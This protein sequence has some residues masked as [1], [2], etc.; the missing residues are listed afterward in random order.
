MSLFEIIS[1]AY[2]TAA[3][4]ALLSM[5][6]EEEKKD[7]ENQLTKMILEDIDN[8]RFPTKSFKENYGRAESFIK[9]LFGDNCNMMEKI[10]NK[11]DENKSSVKFGALKKGDKFML[12]GSNSRTFMKISLVI[13]PRTGNRINAICIDDKEDRY[14]GDRFKIESFAEVTIVK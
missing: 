3:L 9:E 5:L 8:D 14:I 13:N 11:I 1:D 4:K 6:P 2:E 12:T 7:M 10:K